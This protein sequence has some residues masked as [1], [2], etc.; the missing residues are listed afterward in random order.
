MKKRNQVVK[1]VAASAM[2]API[3]VL[4]AVPT[5]VTDAL[6]AAGTDSVTVAGTVLA[7]IVGIMA[8]KYMRRAL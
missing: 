5:E 3:S 8:F 2:L 7:V 4:A 1:Y 6:T